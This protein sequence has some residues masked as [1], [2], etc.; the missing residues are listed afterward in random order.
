MFVDCPGFVFVCI[1]SIVCTLCC[2]ITCGICHW[3]RRSLDAPAGSSGGSKGAGA[4]GRTESE[5]G[6]AL[7]SL[8]TMG[9]RDALLLFRTL[10]QDGYEGRGRGARHPHQSALAAAAAGALLRPPEATAGGLLR[11]PSFSVL[12]L[13]ALAAAALGAQPRPECEVSLCGRN[14]VFLVA[15][16]AFHGAVCTFFR[17]ALKSLFDTNMAQEI[18]PFL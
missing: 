11:Y 17:W 13:S 18:E 3:Q 1:A 16:R 2:C 12:N 5:R 14:L 15:C 10:C 7:E 8:A 6:V 4:D 9:Q